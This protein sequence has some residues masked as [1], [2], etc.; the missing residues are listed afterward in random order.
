MPNA[1]TCLNYHVIFSTKQRYPWLETQYRERLFAF[2]GGIVRDLRG[3]LL[4]A[5]GMP[6]HIH[7]L[8]SLHPSTSLSDVLRQVKSSSSAWIHTTWPELR[9]FAWQ[10]GYAAFTA[11]RSAL[12][13]VQAYV[14]RQEEHHQRV[15]FQEELREF[16]CRHGVEFDQRY[17]CG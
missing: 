1:Y 10:D 14:A 2:M 3:R 13:D 16:L 11:S 17:V 12:D 9:K 5:G 4:A 8:A 7:L 15:S 6:D